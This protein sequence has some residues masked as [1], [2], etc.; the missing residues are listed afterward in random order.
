VFVI[1]HRNDI[2]VQS[3]GY[4]VTKSLTECAM[5]QVKSNQPGSASLYPLIYF[6]LNVK[7]QNNNSKCIVD[8]L[9]LN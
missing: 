1:I 6:R 9:Y 2:F 4:F 3:I 5:R 7:F 8:K